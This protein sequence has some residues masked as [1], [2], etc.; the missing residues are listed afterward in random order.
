MKIADLELNNLYFKSII[1][2]YNLEVKDTDTIT[3]VIHR[4]LFSNQSIVQLEGSS[5]MSEE[6]KNIYYSKLKTLVSK[7]APID[8]FFNNIFT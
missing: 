8:F 4:F 2:K 3:D 1:D 7:G 6:I 5:I